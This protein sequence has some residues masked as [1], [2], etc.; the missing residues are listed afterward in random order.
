[1]N[2]KRHSL[3]I[4]GVG[5]S[6]AFAQSGGSEPARNQAPMGKKLCELRGKNPTPSKEFADKLPDGLKTTVSGR[7]SYACRG[8][9][10]MITDGVDD[11]LPKT[12]NLARL[13]LEVGRCA[14][15]LQVG[16]DE[17]GRITLDNPHSLKTLDQTTAIKLFGEMHSF[18]EDEACKTFHVLACNANGPNI[19]HIDMGFDEKQFLTR[20]RVRGFGIT[21]PVW[22]KVD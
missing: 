16:K 7:R 15:M 9:E 21:S 22:Q 18:G 6:I 5:L 14:G 17:Q 4:L 20:Y 10:G 13:K 11:E 2:R 12:Y 19:F 1:M 3:V 8:I